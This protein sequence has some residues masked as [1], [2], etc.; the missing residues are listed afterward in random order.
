MEGF[1]KCSHKLHKFSQIKART[2]FVKGAQTPVCVLIC[3]NLRN[4]WLRICLVARRRRGD[5]LLQI[6]NIFAGSGL[7]LF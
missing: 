7:Q 1:K 2:P 4:L 5:K 6:K 3:E